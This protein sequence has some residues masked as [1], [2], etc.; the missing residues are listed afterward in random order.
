[1]FRYWPAGFR[2]GRQRAI[3]S[4]AASMCRA[5]PLPRLS[6]TNTE[7]RGSAPRN[8]RSARKTADRWSSSTAAPTRSTTRTASRVPISVPGAELVYRFHE[9]AP[10]PDTFVVVNCGGRTRSI[11]GAQA[12]I[13]AGVPNRV[14]S[15]KDGTMAWH[16]AGFEVVAGAE[17]RA[18]DGLCR[19][20]RRGAAAR[21]GGRAPLR[22]G[23]DRPRHV[24]RMAAARPTGARSM[25]S[26]SATRPST[27]P[28]I[29]RAR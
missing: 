24:G 4:I 23:G 7:R 5:R 9:M 19:R 15:L 10:S 6:S 13:D 25:C 16:L 26:M 3:R 22:R 2:L 28:G 18:P 12:L 11:I 20:D 14:V 27:A 17:R 8:W 29:C 21:G 1:M